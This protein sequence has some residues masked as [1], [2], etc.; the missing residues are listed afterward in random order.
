LKST[1]F[2]VNRLKSRPD[3]VPGLFPPKSN[4]YI[5]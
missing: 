1:K 2:V 3:I 4:D 5:G